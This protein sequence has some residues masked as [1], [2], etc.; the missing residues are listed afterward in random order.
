VKIAV[1]HVNSSK[2]DGTSPTM[3]IARFVA[4]EFKCPLICDLESAR[5]HFHTKFDIVFVKYGMLKF[6][7]HREEALTIYGNAKHVINLENDYLFALDKRFAPPNE[8]WST[9]SNRTRYVNWNMI[10]RHGIDAWKVQRPSPQPMNKGLIYYG[11]HRPDRV[12]S[13]KKYLAKA[14]YDV[15]VSTYRGRKMFLETCGD[16]IKVIGGFKDPDAPAKWPLTLYIED[17]TSHSVY[18]S[19]ATRFYECV[20][21]G[22]AQAVDHE[23]VHTLTE[24]GIKVS[25]E[26]IV[27]NKA[28]VKRMLVNVD[29]V[30]KAQRR[31]WFKDHSVTI[32]AQLKAAAAASFGKDSPL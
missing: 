21:M 19:P 7:N 20:M 10:T 11:A 9:V 31:L 22:L 23:A 25:R 17:E 12:A 2:P 4:D 26:F 8:T 16:K 6:S 1:L 27:E 28:D 18:C 13:F 15:T 29:P 24:A 5:K 3:R 32:R 30:Q 14:P